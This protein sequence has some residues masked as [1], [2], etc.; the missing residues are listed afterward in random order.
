M[1]DMR[2]WKVIG[3]IATG[4]IVLSFPLYLVRSILLESQGQGGSHTGA[5]F[6]GSSTCIDC[7]KLEYD[8]WKGSDHDNAMDLA[9]QETVPGD[10]KDAVFEHNG[11]SHRFYQEEG[12]FR[13][14]TLGPGGIAGDFEVSYTFGIT[15]LQQYLVPF[16]NGR[17]QCLP[18]AWDTEQKR[19]YHLN[20]S[21]Y[22]GQ[23]SAPDDWLYWTNNGQNWNGMCAECHSTNLQKGYDPDTKVFQ[24]TW[25]EIEVS[26]EACHGPSSEHLDWAKLPEMARPYDDNYGLV[27]KTSNITSQEFVDQC[28]YCHSRRSSLGDYDHRWTSLLDHM[29]PQLPSPPRYYPDGQIL[30]EDYVY[31][32]FVQSKM[33][34]NDV[35]CND[36]H[37]SHSLE[38]VADGNDLCLQCHRKEDYDSYNHHFH[39]YAGE[40]GEDLVYNNGKLVYEVGEGA[41]C[42]NCHMPGRYY[43]GV[44]F[45]SDH[46]LRVP[47][48]DLSVTIGTPNACNQC[49]L[50][51]SPEWSLEYT[52]LWYGIKSRPHFGTT[53]AAARNGI[54][55]AVPGL[56]ALALDE[57]V[58]PLLRSAA[59]ELLGSYPDVDTMQAF[60]QGLSD[61][62]AIIRHTAVRHYYS[63]NPEEYVS[64]LSPL[65]RDPTKAVRMETA[66]RLSILPAE[67]QD[68]SYKEAYDEALEEYI[69]AMEYS[70]D[71]AASRHNLG[72]LYTNLGEFD[73]AEKN[74]MEA[75][76][77]DEQFYPSL[78]NL[79]MLYNRIGENDKAEI[80]F[81]DVIRKYP[82][83]D[84]ADYSF[85][86]LLGEVGKYEEALTYLEEAAVRLPDRARVYYNIS[87]LR[88]FMGHMEEAEA[89]LRKAIEIEPGNLDFLYA[90]IEYFINSNR[91]DEAREYAVLII[92]LYPEIPNKQE[93][94]NFINS[95]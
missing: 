92:K 57:L 60:E 4:V 69:K 72:N 29:V 77:I 43:M 8:L 31:G 42:I 73:M 71:F 79:A 58:S 45:R 66:V 81:R 48:P 84:E 39:K 18:I 80:L 62:E 49:H 16:E 37:N 5:A 24:T 76:S 7:H 85:G 19:W 50:D 83:L 25:S 13:V 36:C 9:S 23:E 32:S 56:S 20:D 21:V 14:H 38:L 89:P 53:I 52:R 68:S 94:L 59:L 11:F 54:P 2:N 67:Q 55:E 86:L 61:P 15:P 46:S 51:K 95:E 12:K 1:P 27:V 10:F 47:R 90:A 74:F 93:L 65:L 87:M 75:L 28:A 70:A 30:D 6:V 35:L 34:L 63:D 88:Q 44:D 17:L 40:P 3:I 26:C 78:I 41:L 33:Y 64:K 82:D 91:I 22:A